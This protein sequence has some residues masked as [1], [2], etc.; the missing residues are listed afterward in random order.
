MERLN[1][2]FQPQIVDHFAD[3]FDGVGKVKGVEVKLHIDPSV[4]PKQQQ[5]IRVPFHIRRDVEKELCRLEKLDII[6][7][8]NGPTPCVSAIVVVPKKS[9]AVRICVDMRE[10]N[11][12]TTH[13]ACHANNRRAN[14]IS[15]WLICLQYA[16]LNHIHNKR[17]TIT[18]QTTYVW[19]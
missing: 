9:G 16:G 14:H 5:H 17:G 12:G 2:S 13:R 11:K 1:K 7:R 4:T 15:Q 8:V 10:A 6:D 18:I 19:N 3:L